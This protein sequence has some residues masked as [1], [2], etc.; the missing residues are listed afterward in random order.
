MLDEL[1]ALVTAGALPE[2]LRLGDEKVLAPALGLGPHEIELIEG[3]YASL[4][5]WRTTASST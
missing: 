1:D 4:A 5:R 3:G 2:A